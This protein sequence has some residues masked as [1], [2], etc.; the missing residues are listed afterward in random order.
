MSKTKIVVLQVRKIIYAGIFVV[1]GMIILGVLLAMFLPKKNS[2]VGSVSRPEEK[3]VEKKYEAGVYTKEIE[4]GD[5]TVNLELAL[6]EGQVKSLELVNLEESVETMYP[7]M[8][9]TVK[10][11][12]KKLI[13][14]KDIH[15]IKLSGDA[16]Y[17]EKMILESVETMLEEHKK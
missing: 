9:P 12:E 11:L 10:K 16:K 14:G 15:K 5:S 2:E 13:A 4:I 6:D 3:T 17:T 8:K 7:L 1:L